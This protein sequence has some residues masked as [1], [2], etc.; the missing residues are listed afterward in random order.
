MEME[1]EEILSFWIF[2]HRFFW[3]PTILLLVFFHG[4]TRTIQDEYTFINEKKMAMME[5]D[6]AS[7]GF[8]KTFQLD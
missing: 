3:S 2:S 7:N 5:H 1:M 4:R 6:E 8:Y